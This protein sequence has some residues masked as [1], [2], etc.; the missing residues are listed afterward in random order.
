M[1]LQ[2]FEIRWR[3]MRLKSATHRSELLLLTAASLK[4]LRILKSLF[5]TVC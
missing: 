3:K 1:R 4:R 2:R 5:T